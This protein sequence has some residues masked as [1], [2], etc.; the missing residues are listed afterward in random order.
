MNTK[1]LLDPITPGE[2]L[3]EDFMESFGVSINQLARIF[4][5]LPIE[6]VKSLT[7]KELSLPIPL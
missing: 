7:G 2:I 3:R 1:M 5:F 6:S 4:P